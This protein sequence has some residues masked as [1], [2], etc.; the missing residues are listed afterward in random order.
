MLNTCNVISQQWDSGV[1]EGTDLYSFALQTLPWT[2][3]MEAAHETQ[4]FSDMQLLPSDTWYSLMNLHL[5]R[6]GIGD[7]CG[8]CAATARDQIASITLGD[9]QLANGNATHTTEKH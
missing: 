2:L 3:G 5:P 1:L 9:M 6:A 8:N 7:S 4:W